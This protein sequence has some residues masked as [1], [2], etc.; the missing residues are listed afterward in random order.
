MDRAVQRL[1]DT[2]GLDD[3]EA[4]Q[5]AVAEMGFTPEEI[6]DE[7][8]KQIRQQRLVFEEVQRGIFVSEGEI[9]QFYEANPDEFTAPE[10]IRFD[11]AVFL[12]HAGSEAEVERQAR[13]ALAELRAGAQLAD[14]PATY[15]AVSVFP[16]DEGFIPVPDLSETIAA[17]V[18]S[19]SVD[20]Y[21]EPV[22]SQFGFHLLRLLER[23][24]HAVLPLEEA[25]EQIRNR[26]TTEKSQE[27]MADYL[28]RLREDTYLE[29]LDD[30]YGDIEE[31]WKAAQEEG[32]TTTGR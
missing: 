11:Q 18:P 21:S 2:N 8:R 10:Q 25:S 13:A 27:R 5:R 7:M 17:A 1:R 30:G 19:L 26:L 28:G 32:V 20:V 9:A 15:S 16:A 22:R 12:L 14:L 31:V 3:D 4:F 24:E 6:R 29:I 23:R